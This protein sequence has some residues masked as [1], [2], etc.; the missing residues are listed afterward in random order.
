MSVIPVMPEAEMGGSWFE[1]S[2]GKKLAR[3]YLKKKKTP[4]GY[5]G[6]CLKSQQCRRQR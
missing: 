3:S 4:M 2:P 1:T 5:D 6:I